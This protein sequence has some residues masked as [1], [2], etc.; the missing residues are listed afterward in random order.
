[1][2]SGLFQRPRNSPRLDSGTTY[3]EYSR[4]RMTVV[5]IGVLATIAANLAFTVSRFLE[6]WLH[7]RP[8]PWWCN[9]L[10]LLLLIGL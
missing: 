6:Q 1:M 4:Y 10:S 8:T 7:S 3:F 9:G 2:L 5:Q